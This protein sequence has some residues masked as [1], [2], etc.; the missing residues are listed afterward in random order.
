M[1]IIDAGLTFGRVITGLAYSFGNSPERAG[2]ERLRFPTLRPS[3]LFPRDGD[4]A[5]VP[6]YGRF[7]DSPPVNCVIAAASVDRHGRRHGT[8]ER[9]AGAVR[10]AAAFTVP[11]I[12]RVSDGDNCM[13]MIRRSS[14]ACSSP[15]RGGVKPQLELCTDEQC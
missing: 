8:R 10:G 3:H 12:A 4:F 2:A 11:A 9:A 6:D 5:F 1:R 15:D 13:G 7:D 14:R